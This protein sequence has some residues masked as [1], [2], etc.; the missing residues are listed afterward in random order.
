[1]LVAV[2]SGEKTDLLLLGDTHVRG[3]KVLWAIFDFVRHPTST[4]EARHPSSLQ[5]H[6][7]LDNF[8][9]FRFLE[10]IMLE[11]GESLDGK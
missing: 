9:V 7:A 1:L 11:F 4:E 6:R 5:K 10:R 3:G 2:L 8:L